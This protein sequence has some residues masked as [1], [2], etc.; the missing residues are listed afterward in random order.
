MAMLAHTNAIAEC[1]LDEGTQ[2]ATLHRWNMRLSSLIATS[3][4]VQAR[5]AGFRLE[6]VT[7]ANSQTSLLSQGKQV[8]AAAINVITSFKPTSATSHDDKLLLAATDLVALVLARSTYHPEW[9]RDA[10]GAPLVQRAVQELV[11]VANASSLSVKLS[12]VETI[13]RLAPLFPTALRSTSNA[14]HAL[15]IETICSAGATKLTVQTGASLFSTLYLLAPKGRDGLREAWRKGTEALVASIDSLAPFITSDIF[16][17]D[18][19]TNHTLVPL[20]MPDLFEPLPS[21]GLARAEALTTTL[22]TVLRT[23]TAEK[24]GAMQVPIGAI[25]ELGCRLAGFNADMPIKDRVD[26]AIV[27]ST[28]TLLARLQTLGCQIL[29]QLALCVGPALSAHA[30]EVLSTLARSLASLKPRSPM[31]AAFCTTYSLIV[32]AL[33][34]SIDPDDGKKHLAKV[35]RVVLEDIG[36]AALGAV[37]PSAS[38][39]APAGKG[40]QQGA[41]KAKKQ[42]VYDPSESMQEKRVQVDEV[43]LE[44]AKQALAT[45]ERLLIAPFSHFLPAKLQLSTSRLLLYLALDPT[46]F[47]TFA[48]HTSTSSS[49]YVATSASLRAVD[50]AKQDVEFRR[51]VIRCLS[52][53]VRDKAGRVQDGVLERAMQVFK[54]ASRDADPL[55]QTLSAS[56]LACLVH[57]T[58]PS[59]PPLDVNATFLKQKANAVG[60]NVGDDDDLRQSAAE[61]APRQQVTTTGDIDS[62]DE[63]SANGMQVDDDSQHATRRPMDQEELRRKQPQ[64]ALA[65]PPPPPAFTASTSGFGASTNT[66]GGG[67]AFGSAMGSAGFGSAA[68]SSLNATPSTEKFA[69]KSESSDAPTVIKQP[70]A[71]ETQGAEPPDFVQDEAVAA[72]ERPKVTGPSMDSIQKPVAQ[73]TASKTAGQIDEESDNDDEAMPTINMDSDDE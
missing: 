57:I 4:P 54:T 37:Y 43:D 69:A 70:Q 63:T 58:H 2:G 16:S 61:F 7:L 23:P 9:A 20:A 72:H 29:A 10:V 6:H 21:V 68:A 38:S 39:S 71:S 44:L 14:L 26:P 41:R 45:L 50:I 24:A 73:A 30:S 49:F 13:A 62:D 56:T 3:A 27:T 18:L 5:S 19:L 53:L 40:G 28:F 1:E 55:V 8:L 59:V 35:W 33:G 34:A 64:S 42:R 22:C 25:V 46:F 66:F 52:V 47:T 51:G 48:Q 65:A 17:E 67:S 31:R 60:G 36:A 15:A 32:T 11:S 12:I